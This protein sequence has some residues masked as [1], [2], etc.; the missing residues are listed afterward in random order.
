MM[1]LRG[2]WVILYHSGSARVGRV[3]PASAKPL[4]ILCRG[5]ELNPSHREDRQWTIPL[6]YHSYLLGDISADV[7]IWLWQQT[8][9]ILESNLVSRAKPG[10]ITQ[11]TTTDFRCFYRLVCAWSALDYMQFESGLVSDL[12]SKVLLSFQMDP[13]NTRLEPINGNRVVF[14]GNWN[15]FQA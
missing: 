11:Y 2:V 3:W 15:Y 4:E 12:K 10:Y 5:W 14:L 7:T 8:K 13:S 1:P 9:H 6:S